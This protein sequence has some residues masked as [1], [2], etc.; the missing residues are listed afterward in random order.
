MNI[1]ILTAQAQALL[2][3]QNYAA[4]IPVLNKAVKKYPRNPNLWFMLGIAQGTL[5]DLPAAKQAFLRTLELAPTAFAAWESLGRVQMKLNQPL[6]AEQSFRK[7]IKLQ[8]ANPT[9]YAA[10]G[11]LWRKMGNLQA[12]AKSLQT[13]LEYDPNSA[14]IHNQMGATYE[15]SGA[16]AEA[17]PYYRQALAL[18]PNFYDARYNL[19]TA[20][21]A[22]GKFEDAVSQFQACINQQPKV[23]LA[24]HGLADCLLDMNHWPEALQLYQQILQRDPQIHTAHIRIA[25]ILI[26]QGNL[27]GARQ[28]LDAAQALRPRD[29]PDVCAQ[30]AELA[31]IEGRIEAARDILAPALLAHPAHLPL[32]LAE[33]LLM[34]R[35]PS[36]SAIIEKLEHFRTTL[37]HPPEDLYFALGRLYERTGRYGDAFRAFQAA[38]A[39]RG[40]D[41]DL[42][43][44]LEQM[45]SLKTFFTAERLTQLT[46]SGCE[47]ASPIFIVGMPRS[48]TSL[49]EQI[50]AS[51]PC[52]YGAGE[53]IK[54]SEVLHSL[55]QKTGQIYPASLA[56]AHPTDLI[57]C[58]NEYLRYLREQAGDAVRL[59]DKL[60]HNFLHLGAIQLLFPRA[61]VIHCRRDPLDTCLSIFTQRFNVNHRYAQHL[62]ALGRYYRHYEQLMA[63]WESTLNLKIHTLYYERLIADQEGETRNL[64][65]A[66]D[67]TWDDACLRFFESGRAVVTPSY[68]QVRRP[69]Y[70]SS[71]QRSQRYETLLEPLRKSLQG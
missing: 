18:A 6:K 67:L 28:H 62:E 69:L 16:M 22:T 19:A 15:L 32:A 2:Q 37:T 26:K 61:T 68:D 43:Q 24:W 30:S 34:E 40:L 5:D 58:A 4:A 39:R 71:V 47:D 13:A 51:H 3:A 8:P 12:S 54:L 45:D 48:G 70:K 14:T 63:Y 31:I 53:I 23:I 50:L 52:V 41:S 11:E 56:T 66:A 36:T 27:Q 9:A 38:H 33:A 49:A 1:N 60:P 55:D 7:S 65:E 20:L 44:H 46:G 10:Q 17:I 21:Y 25:R 64:L 57:Q 35:A 42:H 59:C 29:D